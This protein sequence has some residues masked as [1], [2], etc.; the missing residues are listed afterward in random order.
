VFVVCCLISFV[1]SITFN[2]F[3]IRV[4]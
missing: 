1:V 2:P 3:D 4:A